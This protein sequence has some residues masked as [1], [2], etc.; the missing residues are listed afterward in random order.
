MLHSA[1][2]MVCHMLYRLY[3]GCMACYMLHVV[4][5]MV[6]LATEVGS[7]LDVERHRCVRRDAEAPERVVPWC[8]SL[9]RVVLRCS[10]LNH[11]AA[12]RAM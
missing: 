11:V 4:G 12:W 6:H 5:C 1:R 10:V 7:E 8:A 2:C 3:F 9:P